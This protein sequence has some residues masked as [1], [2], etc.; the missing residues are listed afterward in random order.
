MDAVTFLTPVTH[1]SDDSMLRGITRPLLPAVTRR[2][3]PGPLK[4]KPLH[5]LE[6]HTIHAA[7]AWKLSGEEEILCVTADGMGDGNSITVSR[8]S[9]EKGI[10]RLWVSRSR[11]SIGMF[12]EMLTEAMG[13]VSHRDEGKLTGL[14]AHGDPHAVKLPEPFHWEGET[15]VYNGEYG[16][17][18]IQWARRNLTN[19]YSREDIAAWAQ[20]MLEKHMIEITRRGLKRTGLRKAA[21]AGGIFANVK[22]NQHLNEL[23]GMDHLFVYPNMG[24]AGL[25]LGCCCMDNAVALSPVSDVF[26]GEGYSEGQLEKALNAAGLK[27]ERMENPAER[28]AGLLAEDAIVARFDGRMEWG[29]RALGN[30]SILAATTSRAIVER[31]NKCLD[32]SDFMPFAPAMLMEDAAEYIMGYETARHAAEFMTVCFNC[33][34]KMKQEHPAVVHIDGTV[35]AQLVHSHRNPGLH[36]IMRHYKNHTGAGVLLNTSFN[37]HEEPIVRTPAEGVAAFLNAGIDYLAIGPWL[38]KCP[39]P[40]FLS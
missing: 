20:W 11:H 38:A 27:Y 30:R 10:E 8:C 24:D 34:E 21:L 40:R 13:F 16:I 39:A 22:L 12:F 23:E 37:I 15:L 29:P 4:N 18:G 17:R 1:T 35:R 9:P 2:T 6:H 14:A 32:R 19:T 7:G 25:A 5:F 36:A 31:L 26:W 3:L 28:I 33:T